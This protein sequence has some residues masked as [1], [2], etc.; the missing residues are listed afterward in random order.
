V[1]DT[2]AI[3]AILLVTALPLIVGYGRPVTWQ[4]R[5]ALVSRDVGNGE[6]ADGLDVHAGPGP[7]VAKRFTFD[8]WRHRVGVA[9]ALI[10][11]WLVQ[12]VATYV[13]TRAGEVAPSVCFLS[14]FAL[15]VPASTLAVVLMMDRWQRKDFGQRS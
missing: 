2:V 15:V 6:A 13:A 8:P 7:K 5:P 9:F 3:C 4:P 11:L 12:F 1:K 14:A 10:A